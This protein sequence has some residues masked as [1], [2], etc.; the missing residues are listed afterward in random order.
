MRVQVAV[1]TIGALVLY[2]GLWLALG[3][4]WAMVAAGM[5]LVGAGLLVDVSE[6][7]DA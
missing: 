2:A 1:T 4:G 5:M 7:S 3:L 6:R